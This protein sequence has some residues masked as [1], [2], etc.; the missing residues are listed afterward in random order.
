[1]EHIVPCDEEE[2]GAASALC[3]DC[4]GGAV[5]P[6]QHEAPVELALL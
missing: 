4:K 6:Q 5:F 1:M 3:T 2:I